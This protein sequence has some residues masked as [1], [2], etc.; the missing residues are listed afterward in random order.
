M[1]YYKVLKSDV[2]QKEMESVMKYHDEAWLKH[3]QFDFRQFRFSNE[4]IPKV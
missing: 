2:T 1:K 4:Y 3:L